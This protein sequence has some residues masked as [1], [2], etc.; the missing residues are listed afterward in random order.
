MCYI[1]ALLDRA[2]YI[3]YQ[4]GYDDAGSWNP[5]IREGQSANEKVSTSQFPNFF[6]TVF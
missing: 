2:S 3:Q 1:S 4:L 5:V 6:Q